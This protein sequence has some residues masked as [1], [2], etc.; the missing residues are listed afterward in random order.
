MSAVE[1]IVFP[2][3]Y[4]REAMPGDTWLMLPNVRQADIDELAAMGATPEQCLR[5]GIQKSE[6]A[7]TIFLYGEP[8]GIAGI[9]DYGE[10]RLPWGVFTEAIERHPIPFLRAS[11]AWMRGVNGLLL[12]Y[13]DA[14]Q[15]P[16]IRWLQ[17]LGFAVDE[18]VPYGVNSE[19][20]CRFWRNT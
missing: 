15:E 13:V 6:R 20:F 18:P 10:Y 12:N 4:L 17:W 1:K 3:L 7:T 2:P 14:R 11:R 16:T 19:L 9:I 5:L 8:A